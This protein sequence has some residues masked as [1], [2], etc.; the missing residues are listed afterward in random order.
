MTILFRHHQEN[1]L[2]FLSGHSS[3]TFALSTVALHYFGWKAG[4][5]AD[6]LA[7]YTGWSRV[8]DNKHWL[9]DVVAGAA[10][11]LAVGR[12][13]V[14]P[15]KASISTSGTWTVVP[16]TRGRGAGVYVIRR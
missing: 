12:V 2:S 9:S 10:L 6:A 7:T 15:R 3:S 14:R 13:I 11:G 16:V 1:Q 5:P 4:V 8:R